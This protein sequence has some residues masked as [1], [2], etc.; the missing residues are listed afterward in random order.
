MIIPPFLKTGD[1]V[2][3]VNPGK[4]LPKEAL[5]QAIT[6][7]E[8]WGLTV[9]P[10]A[11]VLEKHNQFAGRDEQRLFDFQKALSDPD[12]QAIFCARGGYGSV[13]IIDQL[14]FTSFLD[15][16][17]WIIGYSDITVF[18]THLNRNH[19]TAT[20]HGPMP[21]EFKD[22]DKRKE[23]LEQLQS[24]LFGKPATI[25]IDGHPFNRSGE[26]EGE[27]VGGNLSVLAGLSGTNSD[28]ETDGK[29]LFLEDLCEELYHLDRMMFTLKKS[30][31]LKNLQGLIIGGFTDMTD[32]SGWF[33][34]E[35]YDIIQEHL[36]DYNYP[37]AYR[38]PTGH[39]HRNYPIINGGR[40]RLEVSSL[41]TRLGY[42]F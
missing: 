29:I 12:I 28:L 34:G 41:E 24:M 6:L 15:H 36:S 11:H 18:H 30:G 37:V 10:G 21:L 38:F 32:V 20:I 1:K 35:A 23:A 5:T 13:R 8:E 33:K 42:Q 7:L 22:R 9:V 3:I 4:V 25:Q 17:K 16:P 40:Y 2:A 14:D 19:R 39:I 31:K 27:L 26:A